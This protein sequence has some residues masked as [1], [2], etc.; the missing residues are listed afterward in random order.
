MIPNGV[1]ADQLAAAQTV[2]AA[3]GEQLSP[4]PSPPPPVSETPAAAAELPRRASAASLVC[5]S[6]DSA[7]PHPPRKP[8][9]TSVFPPD[10]APAHRPSKPA[11]KPT[12]QPP[13]ATYG[14]MI[15]PQTALSESAGSEPADVYDVLSASR[16]VPARPRG[17]RPPVPPKPALMV[18]R[19]SPPPDDLLYDSPR[20]HD[21][22]RLRSESAPPV[23][24]AAALSAVAIPAADATERPQV[25]P[26]VEDA[27]VLHRPPEQLAESAPAEQ[28]G[29]PPL[30]L[31]P[32]SL[33]GGCGGSDTYDVPT[34]PLL[35]PPISVLSR[36]SDT[37]DVPVSP[38][39]PTA[40]DSRS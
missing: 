7:P 21:L 38:R 37:Y 30:P 12:P 27:S 33:L 15:R 26:S 14:A 8:A 3:A 17:E 2:T 16:S 10:A 1:S 36:D 29:A 13:E 24:L 20:S 35:S 19:R 28:G 11:V 34:S 18:R 22:Q 40:A 23:V 31:S 39:R 4:A 32:Y 6:G 25:T 5:Q 9:T